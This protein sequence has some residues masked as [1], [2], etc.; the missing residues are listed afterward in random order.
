EVAD[1]A[2]VESADR[3]VVKEPGEETDP[4]GSPRRSGRLGT[5]RSDVFQGR[6]CAHVDGCERGLQVPVVQTLIGEFEGGRADRVERVRDREGFLAQA[7]QG[8]LAPPALLV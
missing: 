2:E 5:M 7:V 4:D 3:V 1:Q 8:G 6:G